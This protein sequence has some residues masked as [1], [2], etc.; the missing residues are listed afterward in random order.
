[1][2]ADFGHSESTPDGDAGARVVVREAT[3]RDFKAISGLFEEVDSVHREHLPDLFRRAQGSPREESFINGLIRSPDAGVFLAEVGARVVGLV[4][5]I[6][7][8]TPDFPILV[9]L[10][11]AMIDTIVV[12][13]SARGRGI[14]HALMA[15]AEAWA[16]SQGVDRIELNVFTF[17]EAALSFYQGMNYS[18]LS[19][20]MMKHLDSDV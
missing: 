7:R 13:E 14:G 10:H 19:C 8:R 9:P 15:Y 2:P 18:I 1:M 16:R 5:A 20:R 17:N 12:T 6:L 3:P 11:Y 4:V